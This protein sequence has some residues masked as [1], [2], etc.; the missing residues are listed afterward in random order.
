MGLE[1]KGFFIWKIKDCEGGNAAAI[2]NT[3]KAAG[4]THVLLKIADG[5]Y[6]VNIDKTTGTD[7]CPPVVAALR[8][9]GI[10]VW[11]WHYVYGYPVQEAQIAVKRCLELGLNGYAIDAEVEYQQAGKDAAARQFMSEL[12]KGLPK[13]PVALSSFRYPTLHPQL[14]W[15]DF[16]E[17]CDYNMPQVYWANATNA[18]AQLRRCVREFQAMSI[19]R[20]IIP[21]GPV[22][23]LAGWQAAPAEITEFLDTARALGLKGANFFAWEYGRTILKNLWDVI[24]AYPW[25]SQPVADT[26]AEWIAALNSHDPARVANLYTDD[27]VHIT[28]AQ[29]VQ[30]RTAITTWYTNFL[31]QILPNATFKL[32]GSGG[33]GSNRHFTWEATSTKGKIRDGSDTLGLIDG[34]I[35]YHYASYTITK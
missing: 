7:L 35:A 22:D 5:A 28:A 19:F 9:K 25:N 10:Q 14:P 30:G 1:G 16:L 21:T 31:T 20:P 6:P 27:A 2:A 24:A 26:P 23:R 12:R 18:G 8:A 33:V 11:G 29:T 13:L 3:A 15:K 34:K 32:T 4:F 17:K